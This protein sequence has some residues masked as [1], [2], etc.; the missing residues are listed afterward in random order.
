MA[1]ADPTEEGGII[2]DFRIMEKI[3]AGA[4]SRVHIAEHIPTKN[5]CAVKIINLG[6]MKEDEFKG[7]LRE[8]AVFNQVDHPNICHLYRI[9]TSGDKYLLLFME[10]A[11]GGTLLELVNRKKGLSEGEAQYYFNQLFT[12]VRHLHLYHF[13]VHRDLKLENV[14]LGK[15]N[16]VKLTDFGLAGTYYNNLMHTFVGTPGY[17]PPEIIAGNEYTE[18]CDV[19][20]LGICLYAMI[21][22][23]L[24]FSNQNSNVRL[25]LQEVLAFKFPNAFSP[26]LADLLKKMLAP[27]PEERP[28][29][30]Q[31]QDHPWLRGVEKLGTN[32]APQPIMFH[33]ARNVAAIAKFKRKK[34]VPKPEILQKCEAMGIDVEKLKESLANGDT[35]PDTTAYFLFLYPHT[36]KPVIKKPELPPPLPPDSGKQG[37][38]Q[39]PLTREHLPSL[40]GGKGRK[41]YQTSM[42]N[43][44][45]K[46]RDS[47]V[48]S[49]L[50][51]AKPRTKSSARFD[52]ASA[53]GV[54]RSMPLNK[55]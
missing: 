18:K 54:R 10:Y 42:T 8:I 46:R 38:T 22:G 29:L 17:Q 20:S 34:T 37:E 32:I 9:S 26:P 40:T 41:S 45:V 16:V 1:A 4:F 12:A 36:E 28:S 30:M 25:F 43:M 52:L 31:L 14:L 35:T 27:K 2:D 13:L 24:P 39:L 50:L 33:M 7:M 53:A 47:P 11:P 19:W 6:E 3:G 15:K 55:P 23:R 5:Y 21:V 44:G 48:F 51:A 49:R